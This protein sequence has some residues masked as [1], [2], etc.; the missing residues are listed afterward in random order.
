MS[1]EN[2][3]MYTAAT[4]SYNDEKDEWDDSID[5]NNPDNFKNNNDE[6]EEFVR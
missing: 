2:I 3:L 4:P 1:Y 5:A 6:E